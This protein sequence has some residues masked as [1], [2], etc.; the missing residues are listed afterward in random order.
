MGKP[1]TEPRNFYTNP[2]KKGQLEY[3]EPLK[4]LATSDKKD[5]FIEESRRLLR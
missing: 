5:I 4:A 3:F 2:T 1:V